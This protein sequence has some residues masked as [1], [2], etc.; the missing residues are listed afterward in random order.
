MSNIYYQTQNSM[1]SILLK[2]CHVLIIEEIM[3]TSKMTY[4]NDPL[5]SNLTTYIPNKKKGIAPRS[6]VRT[7][8]KSPR[9]QTQVCGV[10]PPLFTHASRRVCIS[11]YRARRIERAKFHVNLNTTYFMKTIELYRNKHTCNY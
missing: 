9:T 5:C 3:K 10:Y 2:M 1:R 7:Y 4:E 6:N 11:P 8:S